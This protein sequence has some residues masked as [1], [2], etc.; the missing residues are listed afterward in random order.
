MVYK[1]SNNTVNHSHCV[2]TQ[3]QSHTQR[4]ERSRTATYVIVFGWLHCILHIIIYQIKS[5]LPNSKSQASNPFS[6]TVSVLQIRNKKFSCWRRHETKLWVKAVNAW[7]RS[8]FGNVF[9]N[10]YL[11]NAF[12]VGRTVLTSFVWPNL[13]IARA[14]SM[15]EI[16]AKKWFPIWSK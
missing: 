14:C 10:T 7:V 13:M 12:Q 15:R 8:A 6:V 4:P 1:Y 9:W 5:P 3:I 2:I 11:K 16:T